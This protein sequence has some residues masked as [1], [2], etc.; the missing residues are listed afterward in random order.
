MQ[1]FDEGLEIVDVYRHIQ[2]NMSIIYLSMRG[3]KWNLWEI[4]TI[5]MWNKDV[6]FG[7]KF[8]LYM[9]KL[10]WM[11]FFE[12]HKEEIQGNVDTDATLWREDH[13]EEEEWSQDVPR[14]GIFNGKVEDR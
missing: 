10:W 5:D 6:E 11:M 1:Q 7:M 8:H 13:D 12:G 9:R 2:Y 14:Q 4:T 3:F